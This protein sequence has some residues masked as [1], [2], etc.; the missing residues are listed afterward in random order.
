[1]P[2]LDAFTQ[3]RVVRPGC[4]H[5]LGCRC[6][7]PYWLRPSSLIEQQRESLLRMTPTQLEFVSNGLARVKEL[8]ARPGVRCGHG[9][10]P[11]DCPYPHTDTQ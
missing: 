6:E 11:D 1:M 2:E 5:N 7:A 10:P 3:P 4:Q 8:E 9:N